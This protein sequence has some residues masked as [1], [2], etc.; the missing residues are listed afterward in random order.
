MPELR[1][2][3]TDRDRLTLL[4]TAVTESPLDTAVQIPPAFQTQMQTFIT[5]YRPAVDLLLDLRSRR[6][7]EV[8]EKQTAVNRLERHVR[9]FWAVLERR[10]GRQDLP[11]SLFI[12]YN[13]P[14][15]GENPSGGRLQD[16]LDRAEDIINGDAIAV[17]DGFEPMSNPNAAEVAAAREAAVT[18]AA[19]VN[20]ADRELDRAQHALD[21]MRAEADKLI[22]LLNGQLDL[23][24]YGLSADDAR[25]TKARYG[26]TYYERALTEGE[27]APAPEIPLVTE[28][29]GV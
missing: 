2:P 16:W 4:A 23:A 1:Y 10:I 13:Q 21:D 22:R 6:G 28:E 12:T 19:D 15:S 5:S 26:F 20:T 24:L 11:E 18:E 7:R 3:M 8:D 25:H 17:A 27:P 14:R 9:D 29:P